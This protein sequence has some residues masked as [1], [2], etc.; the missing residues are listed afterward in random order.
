MIGGALERDGGAGRRCWWPRT[1]PA[2]PS[3]VW[4]PALCLPTEAPG[5]LPVACL[6]LL[7]FTTTV[8]LTLVLCAGNLVYL[9]L[10]VAFIQMLK[11]GG[12]QAVG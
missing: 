9:Y 2:L 10:T 5:C 4:L 8:L 12:R 6:P 3:S 11:V 7:T 1:R